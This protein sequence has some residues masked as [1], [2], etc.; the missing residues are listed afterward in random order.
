MFYHSTAISCWNKGIAEEYGKFTQNGR[1]FDCVYM[2]PYTV[3]EILDKGRYCLQNTDGMRLK[4]LYN[5]ILFKEYVEP[6]DSGDKPSH[7]K[8]QPSKRTKPTSHGPP[9]KRKVCR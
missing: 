3:A 7:Q 2:G 5:G 4:K 9:K 8:I 6:L 1:K